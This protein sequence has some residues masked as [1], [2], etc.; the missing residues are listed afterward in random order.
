[1]AFYL[2]AIIGFDPSAQASSADAARGV[3]MLAV[4]LPMALLL[5]SGALMLTYPITQRR[6]RAI[7]RALE[8]RGVAMV[9]GDDSPVGE[10][11]ALHL[12]VGAP[13]CPNDRSQ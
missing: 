10:A 6:H 1:M 5:L 13:N 12:A 11:G 4:F 2:L 3:I 7:R 8:R 9:G